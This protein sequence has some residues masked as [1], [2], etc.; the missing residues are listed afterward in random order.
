[1]N[2]GFLGKS[3]TSPRF[4]FGSALKFSR[5]I[6]IRPRRSGAGFS[7]HLKDNCPW[8]SGGNSSPFDIGYSKL[9]I[10]TISCVSLDIYKGVL[11][12]LL[13][14]G[15]II[16]VI[17]LPFK[18]GNIWLYFFKLCSLNSASLSTLQ[19][20]DDFQSSRKKIV[21]F[22]VNDQKMSKNLNKIVFCL[23]CLLSSATKFTLEFSCYVCAFLW[24]AIETKL[25]T[26]QKSVG[27]K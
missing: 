14:N 27:M 15:S 19:I 25:N 12:D 2:Q 5:K 22:F 6:S 20:I 10:L 9:L 18:L 8:V 3:L 17:R 7:F 23:H 4:D 24:Y 11:R 21:L 1:V 16:Q 13:V 26:C